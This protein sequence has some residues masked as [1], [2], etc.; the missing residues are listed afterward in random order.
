MFVSAELSNLFRFN[1]RAD[2]RAGTPRAFWPVAFLVSR[3]PWF[4]RACADVL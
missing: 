2:R 3:F 1:C 4:E